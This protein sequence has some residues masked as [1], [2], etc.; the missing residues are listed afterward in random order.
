MK[1][2][3]KKTEGFTLV[4][5]IVVIA[6]LGILA[7]V[8]IPAYSGYLKKAN[9]AAVVTELD[10][11]AT[12]AQAA[13]AT[14]GEISKITVT[15]NGTTITVYATDFA[16]KYDDDFKM[17]YSATPGTHATGTKVFTIT[18]PENWANSSYKD[19]ATWVKAAD[20]TF[21]AGWNAKLASGT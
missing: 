13:N 1:K 11:I 4:E 14:A 12:A 15:A 21:A 16:A 5:L 9:D 19:G 3:L 2:F 17:F 7:G 10:A 6:I 18:A 8:A 20:A